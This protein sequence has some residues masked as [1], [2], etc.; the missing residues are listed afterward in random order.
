MSLESRLRALERRL[1]LPA[2]TERDDWKQ[3]IDRW[4]FN[5][6]SGKDPGPFPGKGERERD[7]AIMFMLLDE[8]FHGIDK[9]IARELPPWTPEHCGLAAADWLGHMIQQAE[10]EEERRRQCTA[11]GVTLSPSPVL[12]H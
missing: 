1:G 12:Q 9:M 10:L 6:A 2:L 8:R 11:N 3:E 7:H 4:R 5:L